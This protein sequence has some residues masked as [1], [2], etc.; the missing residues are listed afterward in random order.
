MIFTWQKTTAEESV[1]SESVRRFS[2]M[3]AP[4]DQ[5]LNRFEP[6]RHDPHGY[7]KTFFNWRPWAA[8]RPGAHSQVA[9]LDHYKLVLMQ[10]EERHGYYNGDIAKSDLQHW[11][12]GQE[13]ENYISVD[14]GYTCGKTKIVSAAASHFYDC[15]APCEI[16]TF[17][18]T[19]EQG[20]D[21]F[22]KELISDRNSASAPLLGKINEGQLRVKNGP[23]HFITFKSFER[24][25]GRTE[26]IQGGH[27]LYMM[28]VIDE[29]EGVPPSVF[30]AIEA[31]EAN[32]IVSVVFVVR[33]PASRTSR[34]H[35]IRENSYTRP[36]T[37]SLHDFPNV[38]E[39]R[40]IIPGAASR[41]Y[42]DRQL[43]NTD[44]VDEHDPDKYTFEL[45]WK[46]GIIYRPHR[47]YLWKVMGVPSAEDSDDTLIPTGRYDAAR[48][49]KTPLGEHDATRAQ[50][51]LDA[52]RYGNDKSKLY[53]MHNGRIQRAA[54]F[55]K[56]NGKVIFR[57]I[58]HL[59]KQLRNIG[60][61]HISIRIDAGGGWAA[62]VIDDLNDDYDLQKSF[63]TF[64]VYEVHFNGTPYHV[65][66]YADRATELYALTAEQ[67]LNIVIVNAPDELE[68]D[69]CDRWYTYRSRMIKT[70]SGE[71]KKVDIKKI[72]SKEDFRKERQRMGVKRSPDDGDGCVLTAAP[73]YIFK[74]QTRQQRK[75]PVI[76]SI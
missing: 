18:P 35:K 2:E 4:A 46:P 23:D 58:K 5:S 17:A 14:A 57:S 31:M 76:V 44:I 26:R 25:S 11:K 45:E 32:P 65:E 34:A 54:E 1:F 24:G 7:I 67:L 55:A 21:L 36:F 60:V 64:V 9:I 61:L 33:N 15:Y 49:R 72:V 75:R 27:A 40:P 63:A 19:R 16:R 42:V 50:I 3:L 29:A 74:E 43:K 70:R 13:I 66:K 37:I 56:Q 12:P 51:G 62:G 52:A 41:L 59:L 38:V 30:D 8:T 22:W 20:R 28:F 48:K 71:K 47:D 73:E 10:Q 6:Y 68:S 53:V 69:L 39:N